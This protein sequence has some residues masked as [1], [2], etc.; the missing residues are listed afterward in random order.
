M[1]AHDEILCELRALARAEAR[2]R[3]S[4]EARLLRSGHIDHEELRGRDRP[5]HESRMARW[6]RGAR[7]H[8]LR[9]DPARVGPRP[10]TPDDVAPAPGTLTGNRLR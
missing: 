4:L 5:R 3:L 2:E 6:R 8:R 9:R 1:L 10:R 7:T